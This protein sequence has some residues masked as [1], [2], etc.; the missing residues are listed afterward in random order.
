MCPACLA[1]A[2]TTLITAA[3]VSSAGGFGAYL[4]A[5]LLRVASAPDDFQLRMQPEGESHGSTAHRLAR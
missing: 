5:K 4:A 2:A 1:T 3:G